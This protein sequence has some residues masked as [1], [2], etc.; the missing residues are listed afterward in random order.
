[1]GHGFTISGN[2]VNIG[3]QPFFIFLTK[4]KYRRENVTVFFSL[5][6]EVR[7]VNHS[8]FNNNMK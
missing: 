2:K 4:I 8:T 3:Q 5:N 1:M 7:V 6:D